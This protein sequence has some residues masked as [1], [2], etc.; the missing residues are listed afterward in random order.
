MKNILKLDIID[1]GMDGCGIAHNQNKTY[2]LPN[3]LKGEQVLYD[4]S[5][6]NVEQVII[7]SKNR[8]EPVCP[9]YYACGG[10]NLQCANKKEQQEYKTQYV[11]N[12]FKKYKV[13]YNKNFEYYANAKL[14]YRNKISFAVRHINGKNVLGLFQQGTHNVLKITECK[15][16]DINHKKVIE[17]LNK[18]LALADVVGFNPQENSGN[19]RNIVVRFLNGGV[20]V[21]VVGVKD[22]FLHADVLYNL[23]K[24]EFK[25][26]GLSYCFNKNLKTILSNNIKHILG[27]SEI[28]IKKE[29]LLVPISIGSFLQV[30]D[31]TSFRIYNYVLSFCNK[32]DV[33]LDLYSGAGV[34][35]AML[36]KNCKYVIGVESNKFASDLSN[37]LFFKNNIKNAVGILGKVEDKLPLLLKDIN[38]KKINLNSTTLTNVNNIFCVLDPPRKGCDKSVLDAILNVDINNI[39]YVSCNPITLARDL[40]ILS[41]KYNIVSVKLFDM[42]YLTSHIE[43]VVLLKH[44]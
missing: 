39:I 29:N 4:T 5:K 14:N 26:V 32:N 28:E 40:Q 7:K 16:A 31:E 6:N 1:Y 25:I 41:K 27:Q 15:I 3:V 21:C 38:N 33:V 22:E 2:F 9:Y 24:Q 11:K 12:C 34:M 42:F 10:C 17:I 37:S 18:Y 30:D 13:E 23:L 44:K 43:S 36:S 35:T 8:V 20:L 19:I